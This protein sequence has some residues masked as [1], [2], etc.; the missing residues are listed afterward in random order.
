MAT[1][2]EL[3]IAFLCLSSRQQ[4]NE[5]LEFVKEKYPD[6]LASESGQ[7]FQEAITMPFTEIARKIA[8]LGVALYT[9][10]K[11]QG[12]YLWMADKVAQICSGA[13]DP[14]PLHRRKESAHI[15]PNEHMMPINLGLKN[16]FT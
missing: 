11:R 7:L 13:R 15:E 1:N 5:L 10:E 16:T 6:F 8:K 12:I 2:E 4:Q 3:A 9:F 14:F